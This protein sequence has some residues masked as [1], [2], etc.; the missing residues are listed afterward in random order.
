[1]SDSVQEILATTTGG[2]IRGRVTD[3]VAA[4]LGVPY[5]AAPV[6][7]RRFARP[8]PTRWDGERD[9]TAAGPTAPQGPTDTP[10]MPDIS[11]VLGPGWVPGSEYLTVDVRTPDPT[12]SGLPVM[13]FV[14][15]GSFT[16]GAAR[17]P[18][19]DGTR[20]A[21]EGAV[22]VAV[23]YRL[24][25]PG[26][27]DVPGVVA[28]RGLLDQLAALRWVHDNAAA[29]GGDP[30]RITLFGESAGGISVAD[31]LVAAPRGLVRRAIVQSG[32]GSHV[33]APEQAAV[34][35]RA[36]AADLGVAPSAL[37]DVPDEG[38]VAAVGR[39]GQDPPD[40]AV[41]G[42]RDPLMGLAPLGPV[43]D[44][45]LLDGQPV[46]AFAAGAAADV[47]LLVGSNADE[48][49]L[50]SVVLGTALGLP[51]PDEDALH[52]A[53]ARL[54][55]D[56]DRVIAA[57]RSAGRGSTPPEVHDAVRT[58]WMFGV[59]TR[60]FAD[61]HTGRTWRYAFTWR[62]PGWD[63]RLGATHAIELPFVFDVVGRVDTGAFVVPDTEETRDL[64]SRMC[65]AWVDFA[66][67][68]DP[69]WPGYTAEAPTTR[70]F[71]VTDDL[72]DTPDGPEQEVW[73]GVR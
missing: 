51:G 18:V 46:D 45:E 15:G 19:Y 61:A 62:S 72:T 67:D 56:P 37:V 14:H 42:L 6:G 35:T 10:G 4:F 71:D 33:L 24:G 68:G 9:A 64:A 8:E 12:G 73:K 3:G 11:P 27:A 2:T 63:G 44:G 70:V 7:S 25:V 54:H 49:T 26:F 38:L 66:R 30:D 57:Y 28:N 23:N 1:V 69:G 20:L 47:D 16:A 41:A 39:L 34:T 59:P 21:R 55:D 52:A 48:M 13:V 22:V 32:G 60:R 65:R 43:I 40:L 29:F 58:D 36:L 31:L 5:A 53:V 50:Y 17:A